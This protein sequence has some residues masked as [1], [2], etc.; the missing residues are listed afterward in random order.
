RVEFVEGSASR[1]PLQDPF[2]LIIINFVLHWV[3][4]STLFA[5]LAEIDRLLVDGGHL[6]I[7]DFYPANRMRVRYHHL[8]DA[9][10]YTY[11]QDYS[12]AFLASGLYHQVA[13]LTF[14]HATRSLRADVA[15][16]ERFA[17]CLL[18]KALSELYVERRLT[19]AA[20]AR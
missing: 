9:E 7:G 4:R 12:A 18:R 5:T 10:V 13:V 11:K 20:P 8:P 14:D 15:E 17:T 2:D 16:D 3:D 1:I 19:P 6:I